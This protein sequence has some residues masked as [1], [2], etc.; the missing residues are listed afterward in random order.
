MNKRIVPLRIPSKAFNYAYKP[1]IYNNSRYLIFYGG[2]GSG[3]SVFIVQRYIIKLWTNKRCNI[4]V[5]RNVGDTNRDSTFALFKQ[6]II[7]WG[8][9][10]VFKINESDLK[11]KCKLNGNEIVFKGLDDSE[12]LKSITFENGELTD[13]WAEEA[14]EIPEKD[15]DGK[16]ALNQ[17]DLRL[18]GI[19]T[20]KQMVVS[21]NPVDVNH[22]LKKRFFDNKPANTTVLHTTYKDNRFL[23]DEYRSLLESYKDTDPYY[24]DVYCLGRW[25]V[26]GKT[27][28][29]AQK[30]NQRISDIQGIKPLKC[31][32]FVY[33]Y[34]DQMI[35][36]DSI[37]W[38][39]AED[40]YIKIFDD[41]K[42]RYPYVLAGDTAGD[43]SDN[44]TGQMIDNTTGKQV[45]VLKHQFDEDL[46]T[47][48][49]YCFGMYY[50]KALLGLETN[51]ST[52]PT[53]ELQRLNYPNQYMREVEDSITNTIEKRFGFKTTKLT[54]PIII[55]ELVEIVR[56][57]TELFN[58][59][60]TLNEMLT[61]VRNEK[62]KPCAKEG[63]HDDLIMA[64][65]IAYYIRTQQS[66]KVSEEQINNG[67]R[68]IDQIKKP[69][70]R[71]VL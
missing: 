19:G 55:S 60:D 43:G 49:M 31:G 24:Y 29:N 39:D 5:V 17:L 21:F 56:E 70:T 62:G 30:V 67:K 53:N 58:D 11:I 34:V 14:T 10:K 7:K 2:S 27:I 15:R 22:H 57:H 13:V 25:G 3:K 16:N 8:L 48:Q 71:G 68:L 61:F 18:R 32:F 4:L 65:A 42:S 45:A 59:V 50:N 41:V 26:T 9:S 33:D 35:V 69:Q 47:K 66:F 51:F 40:G 23:D 1:Y 12:K 28:F 20:E 46:Y 54:R 44:F 37:K 64:M 52:Y 38:H 36:D 63:A 6:I